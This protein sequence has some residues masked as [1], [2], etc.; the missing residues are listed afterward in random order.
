MVKYNDEFN[1]IEAI[2][3]L[4]ENPELKDEFVAEGK[5]TVAKFSVERMIDETIKLISR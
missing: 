1:L 2:K 5:K 3:T 4:H